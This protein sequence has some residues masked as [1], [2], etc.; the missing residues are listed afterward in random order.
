M[1]FAF[2]ISDIM[3]QAVE[4]A[5][6]EYL[7]E[8]DDPNDDVFEGR[9]SP[10]SCTNCSC[11]RPRSPLQ[12]SASGG[13]SSPD[14]KK[15][16]QIDDPN[17]G[18]ASEGDDSNFDRSPTKPISKVST[19]TP[20]K[21]RDIDFDDF[22][23]KADARAC[24]VKQLNPQNFT[25]WGCDGHA[26]L[27]CKACVQYWCK[28]C[29]QTCVGNNHQ[30]LRFCNEFGSDDQVL[31]FQ[32]TY[33]QYKQSVTITALATCTCEGGSKNVG[34]VKFK[35][36][37][38][39]WVILHDG[40]WL[41]R[42][43]VTWCHDCS[44]NDPFAELWAYGYILIKE[45]VAISI[46]LC[47]TLTR[48]NGASFKD[49]YEDI[50]CKNE[51][52]GIFFKEEYLT[53][54]KYSYLQM[55]LRLKKK[56]KCPCCVDCCSGKNSPSCVNS[57]YTNMVRDGS[58]SFFRSEGAKTRLIADEHDFSNE[59]KVF[60]DACQTGGSK[61]KPQTENT[62]DAP[63]E[64]KCKDKFADDSD[65]S[66][67]DADIRKLLLHACVHGWILLVALSRAPGERAQY[68]LSTLAALINR[69]ELF[70]KKYSFDYAC[71]LLK[72]AKVA[73]EHVPESMRKRWLDT[74]IQT[75]TFG[76][77]HGPNH[78]IECYLEMFCKGECAELFGDGIESVFKKIKINSKSVRKLVFNYFVTE[79]DARFMK[80]NSDK[81]KE[82]PIIQMK[83]ESTNNMKI[84]TLQKEVQRLC[85]KLDIDFEGRSIDELLDEIL[86]WDKAGLIQRRSECKE[87]RFVELLMKY[88]YLVTRQK[89][90]AG[91]KTAHLSK[92]ILP[93]PQMWE[94]VCDDGKD[95][96]IQLGAV[97]GEMKGLL[98][99]ISPKVRGASEYRNEKLLTRHDIYQLLGDLLRRK[100]KDIE[101]ELFENVREEAIV[102]HNYYKHETKGV[103]YLRS[104]V[105]KTGRLRR[106]RISQLT[107]R[108]QAL[109]RHIIKHFDGKEDDLCYASDVKSRGNDIELIWEDDLLPRSGQ[110]IQLYCKAFKLR[111]RFILKEVIPIWTRRWVANVLIGLD[112]CLEMVRE[113][114]EDLLLWQK[115][116]NVY[117]KALNNFS[118][119][120]YAR[121]KK[122]NSLYNSFK[123]VFAKILINEASLGRAE[124][125]RRFG[126]EGELDVPVKPESVEPDFGGSAQHHDEPSEPGKSRQKPT[127]LTYTLEMNELL[128]RE[129][130]IINSLSI[131]NDA[132]PQND[133]AANNEKI[134]LPIAQPEPE[135]DFSGIHQ[136][137]AVYQAKFNWRSPE[138]VDLDCKLLRARH[139]KQ[140]DLVSAIN[141]EILDLS[142]EHCKNT[143]LWGITNHP[144]LISEELEPEKEETLAEHCISAVE[145]SRIKD[146]SEYGGDMICRYMEFLLENNDFGFP[147]MVITSNPQVNCPAFRPM[148]PSP[149]PNDRAGIVLTHQGDSQ[150]YTVLVKLRNKRRL[151]YANSRRV[152][153]IN[154]P[155]NGELIQA[156]FFFE[157]RADDGNLKIFSHNC[158]K[159]QGVDC[160][161]YAF[162]Y[163]IL[164][165]KGYDLV[166]VSVKHDVL[167]NYVWACF[168]AEEIIDPFKFHGLCKERKTRASLGK[169]CLAKQN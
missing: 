60:A 52:S 128:M 19:E 6:P 149:V 36:K 126:F 125:G 31:R 135:E 58:S 134:F 105:W 93:S 12:P 160:L 144:R 102:T 168:L 131:V 43:E 98:K 86:A 137:L 116:A 162:L 107:G 75:L 5:D 111:T 120:F 50:K 87:L 88:R 113:K 49:V 48:L 127:L 21:T 29:H 11:K 41:S 85:L 35:R 103:N 77:F 3:A 90:A 154:T 37:D 112:E 143:R 55:E 62:S 74:F 79:L 59:G 148:L 161:Y 2:D 82:L 92:N 15:Q 27:Y 83:Y 63:K 164:L 152:R 54:A 26:D 104:E 163:G 51:G 25:C 73:A 46:E 23:K 32:N 44:S 39:S 28:D 147:L 169:I 132:S 151:E 45:N 153:Q 56:E 34:G 69:E 115:R 109:R 14:A 8:F 155:S 129:I 18:G 119:S 61:S 78:G 150:H 121:A 166:K 22:C 53:L 94:Q 136:F 84:V 124:I 13:H 38:S 16:R 123:D 42:G 67:K 140:E 106:S 72:V 142:N 156:H 57:D 141:D 81:L 99:R 24:R 10:R 117:F 47:K 108:H 118:R 146:L 130:D 167:R 114:H 76:P 159:Q 30:V 122:R 91:D 40:F 145:I 64:A 71:G 101:A 95:F 110:R 138:I 133:G 68:I 96:D 139:A 7:A 100:L 66:R 20:S 65:Y 9:G 17:L 4:E 157:V 33:Q 1:A 70:P 89:Q 97:H 158:Q 165:L 80:W